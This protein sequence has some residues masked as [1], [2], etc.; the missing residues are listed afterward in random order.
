MRDIV[1]RRIMVNRIGV[2][3]ILRRL[4]KTICIHWLPGSSTRR[5]FRRHMDKAGTGVV[6]GGTLT[7]KQ[8]K[9]RRQSRC[10]HVVCMWDIYVGGVSSL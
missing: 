8:D 1:R 3:D 6:L 10:R 9:I 5:V 7:K 2:V 4:C